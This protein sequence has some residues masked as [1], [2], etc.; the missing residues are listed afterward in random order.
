MVLFV[1]L[2][3]TPAHVSADIKIGFNAPLTGF[4]A[5]DGKSA[6]EGAKLAG[7]QANAKGGI[8]GE[9]V[10]LIVY[11]DQAAPKE[12]VPVATKMVEKDKVIGAVSGSYSGSTRAA[13]PIFQAAKIPYVVAYAIHPDITL[14][15]DYMFRTATMGEV[16]GRGQTGQ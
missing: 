3:L 12:A 2:A 5:S 14:S 4:A 16:Q 1:T 8:S 9:K 15:G 13:A 10:E 7:A 11:D 6:L